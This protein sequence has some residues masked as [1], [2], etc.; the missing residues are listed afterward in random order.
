MAVPLCGFFVA[1]AYPICLNTFCR[2][3][4]DGFRE[5]KIGYVDGDGVVRD[6]DRELRRSSLR[7][8]EKGVKAM[9][10]HLEVR[11]VSSKMSRMMDIE[12]NNSGVEVFDVT[13]GGGYE[14]WTR[15]SFSSCNTFTIQR[16]Q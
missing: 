15:G 9:G 3:E 13:E 6:P 1:F 8:K 11:E 2:R 12:D 7:F 14:W 10:G 4:L 16:P 5:T